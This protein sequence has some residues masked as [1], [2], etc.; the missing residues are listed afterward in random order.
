M[1]D[2]HGH[3]EHTHDDS[4]QGVEDIIAESTGAGDSP[5]P[6][7]I[8]GRAASVRFDRRGDSVHTNNRARM[9]AAN[10]SLADALKI[11]YVFL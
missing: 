10:Q 4:T 9:D 1:S 11:T 3:D 5:E 2:P 6:G 7:L 8:S